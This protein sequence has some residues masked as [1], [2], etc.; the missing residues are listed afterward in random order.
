[1][2][3]YLFGGLLVVGLL[4]CGEGAIGGAPGDGDPRDGYASEPGST[5]I[6]PNG[7]YEASVG[8]GEPP[9]PDDLPSVGRKFLASRTACMAPCAVYFNAQATESLTWDEVRDVQFVWDFDDG[10][11][12]SEGFLAAHVFDDPGTY[13]VGLAVDGEQWTRTTITVSAPQRTIC[14]SPASS[15]GDC[16]SSSSS[17][18]FT[19]LSSASGQSHSNVHVLLHRGESFGSVGNLKGQGPTLYGAYG[20]GSKPKLTQ[21]NEERMGD[22]IV[23]QDL[24]VSASR[25]LNLAQWSMLRRIDAHGTIGGDPQHWVMAY[26]VDDF[27]VVDCNATISHQSSSGGGLYVYQSQRSAVQGNSIYYQ[28]G[29]NGHAFRSNGADGFLIQDNVIDDN[30][31]FD[32]LTIRGDNESG[33][34]SA[35]GNAY[36]TLIQG[37]EFTGNLV[38]YKA[39]YPEANELIQYLIHE[40]NLHV[41][42]SNLILA[43]VHDAVVRGNAFVG[44]R[45]EGVSVAD[46]SNYYDPENIEIYDN[47]N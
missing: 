16:P 20:S 45:G 42:G 25:V 18:H 41:D 15:F 38:E 11:A 7:D 21:D 6:D 43:T 35:S 4:G 3:R 37:N 32:V 12:S 40:N 14:V 46:K 2:V 22:Q 24:D 47:T 23:W 8:G 33:S 30:G 28:Q 9:F 36:W 17:D 13:N 27:F 34:P 5:P 19:S 26:H 29:G 39:Q 44:M 1:M 31:S 10:G